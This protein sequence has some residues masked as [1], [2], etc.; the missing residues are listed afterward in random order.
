MY[1]RIDFYKIVYNYMPMQSLNKTDV[2]LKERFIKT[3]LDSVNPN[4]QHIVKTNEVDDSNIIIEILDN[5][6]DGYLF[7]IIGKLEDLKDGVLKRFRNKD[8]KTIIFSSENNI[9]L[10]LENYTYFFIRLHDLLCAVMNNS[11]AP[12][13]RTHFCNY[14]N[15]ITKSLL[16][17]SLN[18]IYVYDNEIE[19]KIN[20]MENLSEVKFVFDD[21][22]VIGKKILNL[23]DTFYMS[24]SNL[25]EAK[26]ELSFKMSPF[27]EKSKDI[28]KNTN[29]LK[30]DFKK[31][32]VTGLDDDNKSLQVELIEQILTKKVFIN[33][34]ETYLR[35]SKDLEKIK[36]ALLDS[37]PSN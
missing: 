37:L 3:V 18:I 35:T 14:L 23:R 15:S 36:E 17:E 13:F 25:R 29:L 31:V 9:N 19:Y 20:K 27:T 26:V 16:L 2:E 33:I 21:S 11:S 34:N 1:K 12:R 5:V 6:Q 22:S 4:Q 7:G 10:Y 32:E 30:T 8:D 28:L 24:Q